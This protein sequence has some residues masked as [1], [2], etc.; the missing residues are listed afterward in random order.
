MDEWFRNIYEQAEQH[1]AER[2]GWQEESMIAYHK[3]SSGISS[4][5]MGWLITRTVVELAILVALI[6]R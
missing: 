1:Q 5:M 3:G 4:L 6:W 2:R